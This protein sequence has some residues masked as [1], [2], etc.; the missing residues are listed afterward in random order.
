MYM[1]EYD[2]KAWWWGTI[3]KLG[4]TPKWIMGKSQLIW[5][6]NH[7]CL[8]PFVNVQMMES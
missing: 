2:I 8:L 6:F 1:Y 5:E 7:N 3:L 4:V